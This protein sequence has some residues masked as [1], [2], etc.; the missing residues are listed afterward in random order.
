MV[1]RDVRPRSQLL[2]AARGTASCP[3]FDDEE[4]SFGGDRNLVK[5]PAGTNSIRGPLVGCPQVAN[6]VETL[7]SSLDVG[8]YLSVVPVSCIS[9]GQIPII[10][11]IKCSRYLRALRDP[12][13]LIVTIPP[14]ASDHNAPPRSC[15]A[16]LRVGQRHPPVILGRRTARGGAP[17]DTR[18]DTST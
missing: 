9:H 2:W 5:G 12:Q 1:A 7:L 4:Q 14:L 6:D 13:L 17:A 3:L 15:H 10:I 18:P 8:E 11:I 16:R